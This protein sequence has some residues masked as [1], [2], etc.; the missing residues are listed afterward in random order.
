MSK[1]NTIL[2]QNAVTAMVAKIKKQPKIF[3]KMMKVSAP[4]FQ[5]PLPRKLVDKHGTLCERYTEV[6]KIWWTTFQRK[7]PEFCQACTTKHGE[8]WTMVK[9]EVDRWM[10]TTDDGGYIDRQIEASEI[11]KAISKMKKHGSPGPDLVTIAMIHALGKEGFNMLL[12]FFNFI[13]MNDFT[14]TI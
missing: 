8:W 4:S 10:L 2:L 11:S 5:R 12:R 13:W 9:Q 7:E 3:W 14:G 1:Q 6:L